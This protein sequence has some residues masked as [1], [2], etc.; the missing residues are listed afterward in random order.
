MN[1]KSINPYNQAIIGE[2]PLMD[3]PQIE[4]KINQSQIAFQ[5]WSRTKPEY[6]AQLIGKFASLLSESQEDL[7]KLISLEM[8]KVFLESKGEV[9]KCANAC[10]FFAD[11]GVPFLDFQAIPT[12]AKYSGYSIEPQGAVLGIM[13]WNFPFWQVIR[14]AIPN[15]LLGNVCLL[16]HAPN[17]SGC[18]LALEKLFLEAGFP[19][20]VFQSLII[21]VD[22]V[23]SI[24]AHDHI[25][26][27]AFTGSESSGSKVAALAGKYLKKTVL[28]LGG[29]DPFIVLEDA[30]I[31]KAAKIGV[32]SR[33]TNAGQACNGAK[34]FIIESKVYPQFLEAFLAEISLWKAGDPFL[35]TSRI[36]PMARLDLVNQLEKQME[37]SENLGARYIL[38]GKID[39]CLVEP[40]IMEGIG[41]YMDISREETFGPLAAFIQV[42]DPEE[43]IHIA[44]HS[45]F[46]LG[47]TVM[48]QDIEKAYGYAKKIEAGNVFINSMVR[49]DPRLPFG[50]IKKSGFGRELSHWG[51]MEF[52]NIKTYYES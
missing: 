52:A 9:Q 50:G 48:S 45:R 20:F 17:V 4:K 8:G 11:N 42:N 6:R 36:G 37:Q 41:E 2:Y 12:E 49:S 22:L 13:P 19:E 5:H 25:V 18:S 28:E 16:K 31:E 14:Y 29:S 40:R 32:Q 46:G 15:L 21:E 3:M 26:G 23:E 24:I 30:D 10:L 38:K 43:A 51:L 7:S 34:R 47:A 39:G 1:F 44:N 33:F 27:V 35:P